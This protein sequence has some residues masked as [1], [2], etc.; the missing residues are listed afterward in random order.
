[1]ST[2]AAIGLGVVAAVTVAPWW[3]LALDGRFI[4]LF[5]RHTAVILVV[6]VGWVGAVAV[7]G[8]VASGV[9]LATVAVAVV[10]AAAMWW[11]ARPQWGTR[12]GLPPGSLSVTGSLRAL[13]D[14]G[15]LLHTTDE[16]GPVVKTAQFHRPVVV[17]V[18]LGRA[19]ELLREQ[20]ASLGPSVL[21]F[22]AFVTG[23]FLRYMDDADHE[24][25]A[26]LFRTA[27]VAATRDTAPRV[28]A[29]A[30]D[31]LVVDVRRSGVLAGAALRQ[32]LAVVAQQVCLRTLL[33]VE[34]D[35]TAGGQVRR[36]LADAFGPPGVPV[37][38]RLDLRGP[39]EVLAAVAPPAS[40]SLLEGVTAAGH[41]PA[42]PVVVDNA[43]VMTALGT[44]NLAGL[45]AWVVQY[46]GAESD[47][48]REH[49]AAGDGQAE[50]FVAEVLRL[51][52][53]EYLYRRVRRDI[54]VDG[55]RIPAG[56]WLRVGVWESHHHPATFGSPE[57]VAARVGP[58]GRG[59]GHSVQTAPFGLDRH[60]CT[61]ANLSTV[62]AAVLARVLAAAGDVEVLPAAGV[63]RGFRHWSHWRPDDSL[64]LRV[65]G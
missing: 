6:V 32:R 13:A 35:S 25:Y 15:A 26:N 58:N 55:F 19:R 31:S 34:S 5:P 37:P 46:L 22:D 29:E 65:S 18:G 57:E 39:R 14:R 27:L 45:F 48:W 47:R 30:V 64:A 40:P 60:A 62:S 7:V 23:H 9:A 44:A 56:W 4:R 49:V 61:G 3:R 24:R 33:G 8:F 36:A 38:A 2:L 52:Q 50:A 53:S 59:E 12:R 42:D 20:R 63:T 54:S 1:V 10:G 21:P 41:D 51:A 43:L 17:V 11:R 16:L 28:T